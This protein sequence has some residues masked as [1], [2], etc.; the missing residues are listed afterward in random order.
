LP[1]LALTSTWAMLACAEAML[2]SR[3]DLYLSPKWVWA[4]WARTVGDHP[5]Q[6]AIEV[7]CGIGGD[8]ADSMARLWVGQ[9]LLAEAL[10]GQP[11]PAKA[12]I[13]ASALARDPFAFPMREVGT[14]T[15]H[16]PGSPLVKLSEPGLLLWAV[17][18][19]RSTEEAVTV[20][21]AHLHH[22]GLTVPTNDIESYLQRLCAL[23]LVLP[24]HESLRDGASD[25]EEWVRA[26]AEGRGPNATETARASPEMV[27]AS[28]S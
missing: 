23:R 11:L 14:V 28:P 17:A 24:P 3:R 20:A 9:G 7:L 18:H 5:S 26:L 8:E 1:G 2:A 19:G 25:D 27:G 13:G 16:R 6:E 21:Q 22:R 15:V 10:L 4:R 12:T